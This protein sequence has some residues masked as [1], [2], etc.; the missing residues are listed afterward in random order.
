MNEIN[1]D[2]KCR[3][4]LKITTKMISLDTKLK[5]L[6]VEKTYMDLLKYI[7]KLEVMQ[8]IIIHIHM[9]LHIDSRSFFLL[10]TTRWKRKSSVRLHKEYAQYAVKR[11]VI[12]TH[13]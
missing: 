11:C 6:N 12:P 10:I 5:M 2:D 13:L 4:C 7:A 8:R 1:K 9:F 3:T